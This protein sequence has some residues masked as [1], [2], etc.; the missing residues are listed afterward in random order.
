MEAHHSLSLALSQT[1]F[2]SFFISASKLGFVHAK[3]TA[4]AVCAANAA[5]TL[6]TGTATYF[7][8]T[9]LQIKK[10]NHYLKNIQDTVLSLWL[11]IC[12][13]S[14]KHENVLKMQYS[15]TKKRTNTCESLQAMCISVIKALGSCYC[16]VKMQCIWLA[17]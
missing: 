5:F 13:L 4:S 8:Y 3:I 12:S 16:S 1:A 17:S 9:H 15:P 14:L 11:H 10:T 2:L 6:P 7:W